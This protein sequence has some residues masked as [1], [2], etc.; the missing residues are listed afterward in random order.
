MTRVKTTRLF[1]GVPESDADILYGTGFSAPDPFL[2]IEHQGRKILL[3][4]DFERDRARAGS[5]AD[6]VWTVTS[7]S[8]E[9]QRRRKAKAPDLT[10]GGLALAALARLR[11]RAVEVPQNFPVGLAN[12]LQGQGIRLQILQEPPYPRRLAKSSWEVRRIVSALRHTELALAA[13][14]ALLR[15]SRP[16][17]NRLLLGTRPLRAEDLHRVINLSLMEANCLAAHTIVAPGDQAVDPHSEGS[18]PIRP[19]EPVVIDVFPRSLD[20]YYFADITRTMVRGK[21][22]SAL[23]RQYR[24]VLEGQRLA[25]SMIRPGVSVAQVHRAVQR[26]FEERGYATGEWRG[27]LQGFTHS[28]GHGVGLEIHE[29]PKI[30]KVEPTVRFKKGMVVTVEPG[31]YYLGTGGV[32]IEDMVLV[33]ARGNTN[34]TRYPKRLLA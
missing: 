31:L 33:T 29:P 34:L 27:R 3:V 25:L 12:R 21:P 1:Y 22:S 7:L 15:H 18:G 20:S 23:V 19:G 17:K 5:K 8:E 11:V 30:G 32:R 13:A 2:F 4:T 14:A 9:D 28:T 16:V 26:L 10:P 6:L 24:A